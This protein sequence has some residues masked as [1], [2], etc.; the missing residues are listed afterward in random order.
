MVEEDELEPEIIPAEA[1]RGATDLNEPRIVES[2]LGTVLWFLLAGSLVAV[3]IL[4][5]VPVIAAVLVLL[6]G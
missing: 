5:V 4:L 3:P 6:F 1:L 2:L